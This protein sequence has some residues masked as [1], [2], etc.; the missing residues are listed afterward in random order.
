MSFSPELEELKQGVLDQSQ[1]AGYH[2]PEHRDAAKLRLFGA[3]TAL[4][5]VG[6]A[7]HQGYRVMHDKSLQIP[8]LAAAGGLGLSA[9][10]INREAQKRMEAHDELIR[11]QHPELFEEKVASRVNE[12]LMEKVALA[13]SS[14]PFVSKVQRGVRR[15]FTGEG[16]SLGA[17]NLI[18]NGLRGRGG[19]PIVAPGSTYGDVTKPTM[20]AHNLNLVEA[21]KQKNLRAAGGDKIRAMMLGRNPDLSAKPIQGMI[22]QGRIDLRAKRMERIADTGSFD[23]TIGRFG[24]QARQGVAAVRNGFRNFGEAI[25]NGTRAL[26]MPVAYR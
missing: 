12:I 21:Q 1:Y 22:P 11:Q 6:L 14:L 19:R 13:G 5:G 18:E 15:F 24:V 20:V 25:D 10:I 7:T 9:Y 26:A 23:R 4:G 8:M 2:T 16:Q 17:Q 3:L